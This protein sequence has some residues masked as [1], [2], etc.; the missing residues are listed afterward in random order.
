MCP[1][2]WQL[3]NGCINYH[4]HSSSIDNLQKDGK[5]YSLVSWQFDLNDAWGTLGLQQQSNDQNI[6]TNAARD[7][8][9]GGVVGNDDH[10]RHN[11]K[12][13]LFGSLRQ[14]LQYQQMK[15]TQFKTKYAKVNVTHLN[16]C[17]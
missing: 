6:G 11:S 4:T 5:K 17:F 10:C 16:V 12:K 13:H 9:V 14:R 8:S 15:N 7:G 1:T 2:G 3:N